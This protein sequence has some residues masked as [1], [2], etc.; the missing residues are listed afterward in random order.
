MLP[1]LKAMHAEL[2]AKA[3]AWDG[4]VKIGRTHTQDA[5]PLTLG[6][7]FSGYARQV[8]A[9]PGFGD[10]EKKTSRTIPVVALTRAG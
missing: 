9:M 1:A 2:A 7:E 4:I 6:Q 3:Q 8:E 10:Y 5:T